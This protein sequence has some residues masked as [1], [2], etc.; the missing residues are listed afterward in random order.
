MR[1]GR[2]VVL[3][4]GGISDCGAGHSC[5]RASTRDPLQRDTLTHTKNQSFNVFLKV[6]DLVLF[7]VTVVFCFCFFFILGGLHE[8]KIQFFSLLLLLFPLTFS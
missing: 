3:V 8:N 6:L 2:L 5:E 7:S 1:N 4:V